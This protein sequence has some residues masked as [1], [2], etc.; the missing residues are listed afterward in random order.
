MPLPPMKTPR[1]VRTLVPTILFAIVGLSVGQTATAGA[2]KGTVRLPDGARSARL[3][4]G[5]WRLENGN[6]PVRA[7]TSKAGTVV[8]LDSIS[9]V[10]AP[11]AKTVT[12]EIAG[13]DAQPR[14]VVV[15]P[16]SVVE[17]KNT[18][19]ITH[20]LSTPADVAIMPIQSLNPGTFRHQKF[21]APGGYLVRCSEYPHLAISVIV[22]DSPYFALVDD[23]GGFQIPS[24]VP[25]GKATLK[26]WSM[27]RWVH[28]ESIDTTG[29]QDLAIR[30][31]GLKGAKEAEVKDP[32]S[33]ESDPSNPEAKDPES[34]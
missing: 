29:K 30:V 27:G 22:V 32:E 2:V 26:V 6:V 17:F 18:G 3:H 34:K 4:Q 12:V 10:H 33:K 14:V 1:L 9:G 15:G 19:K 24:G 8:V 31:A 11:P 20:E 28:Q 16:G 21:G 13:L 23:K 25:D 7:A 5:Y